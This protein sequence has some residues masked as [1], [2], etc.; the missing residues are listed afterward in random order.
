MTR[1]VSVP[2]TF[3]SRVPAVVSVMTPS[4]CPA[5]F[6]SV[7]LLYTM[8]NIQKVLSLLKQ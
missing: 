1:L 6:V 3:V 2:D 8:S 5:S 4:S 7:V